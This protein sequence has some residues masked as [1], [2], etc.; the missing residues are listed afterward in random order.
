RRQ[1]QHQAHSD[2]RREEG[3]L[4]SHH[5]A[6]RLQLVPIALRLAPRRQQQREV[7]HPSADH[8]QID[9]SL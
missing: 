6:S 7:P 1:P 5:S 8:H 4:P 9:C 3:P 2:H